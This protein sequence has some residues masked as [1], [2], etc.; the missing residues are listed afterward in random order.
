MEKLY[1]K[2]RRLD[3]LGVTLFMLLFLT[4]GFLQASSLT[5][6]KPIISFVQW[7]AIALGCVLL[8]VRLLNVK[9]YMRSRGIL[10]LVLFGVSYALSSLW[11]IRYGW[12]ENARTLVFMAFQFGLLY[13]TDDGTDREKT[14]KQLHICGVYYVIGTAVLSL[15]SFFSMIV[16]YARVFY[17]GP[18]EEGP[19]YYIGF[20]YGRLFGV[21]WDPNIAATM[22]ALAVLLSLFF[23]MRRRHSP[24]LRTL[25]I[26]SV[27]L[28]VC[29]I[30]FSGSRTGQL[31]LMAG[32]LFFLLLV[33]I[34]RHIQMN[35]VLL[36]CGSLGV[37]AVT[38]VFSFYMPKAIQKGTNLVIH[39]M[40]EKEQSAPSGDPSSPNTTTPVVPEDIFDRGYDLSEDI[41]NRRFDIWNGA[42]EIFR[43]SP[44]FGV[45]R[46]NIL[47]YVD[48]NLPDSYLVT[49]DHMRFDSMHNMFFEILASQGALGV[50]LFI[51][52]A[53]YVVLGILRQ[54]PSLWNSEEF[55][56]IALLIGMV[57]TVCA[58]TL[59][60]AEIVYVTSPISS[61]F[62]IGLGYLNRVVTDVKREKLR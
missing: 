23:M 38:V 44:V 19:I 21:Y 30:A 29:Y 56:L 49:N 55:P 39:Y 57:A 5:F 60:M 50:I 13:A 34:R 6:G 14:R 35:K 9:Y 10:L 27:I 40:Q 47:A 62:W 59:V 43:T 22:A 48:D 28:Q 18:G 16:G 33:A 17:P 20:W 61:M 15:L 53:V 7:P 36:V 24:V 41:S 31:C 51:A 1:A 2:T 32:I 4:V 46:A 11:T 58:S 26:L 37:I 12:Y 42:V 3:F 45:S 54:W 25:C 8:I 52:F